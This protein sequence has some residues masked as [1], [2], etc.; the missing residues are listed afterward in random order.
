MK[1][2][3][4]YLIFESSAASTAPLTEEQMK[5]LNA[6]TKGTWKFN[7]QTG[8]VDVDGM[9]YCVH[10]NLT[11]FKGVR[12][13]VIRGSFI[14]SH[15]ELTSLKGAPQEVVGDFSC[16]KNKLTSLEGA[17]R[18]IRNNFYCRDNKLT[19]LEGASQTI[20]K[21]FYCDNNQITSLEGAP[22]LRAGGRLSFSG[23]PVGKYDNSDL[24]I[25]YKIKVL[26]GER[27]FIEGDDPPEDLL[28]ELDEFSETSNTD[29]SI[30]VDLIKEGPGYTDVWLNR[31]VLIGDAIEHGDGL[32]PGE[33]VTEDDIW[34]ENREYFKEERAEA[35]RN[36]EK[37]LDPKS[38][39]MVWP[40]L[41]DNTKEALYTP[42]LKWVSPEERR[43]LE[44]FKRY[45]KIKGM[46]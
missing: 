5:W 2:I 27:W 9:F 30:L 1:H 41:S 39:E 3:T 31:G 37:N 8:L 33:E 4:S 28:D 35:M 38:L 14:V 36:I 29:L 46:I 44:A 16:D 17:P 19:S 23:N 12:F 34:E 21:N 11:D 32:S 18:E 25:F 6:Y 13:G 10:Q 26:S 43:K 42:D 45:N 15:N 40:S 7:P 22:N 20:C 24:I